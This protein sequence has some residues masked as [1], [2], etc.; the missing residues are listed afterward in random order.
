[1]GA[2]FLPGANFNGNVISPYALKS[3]IEGRQIGYWLAPLVAP[4]NKDDKLF[5]RLVKDVKKDK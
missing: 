1:M 3:K 2:I 5:V 4:I